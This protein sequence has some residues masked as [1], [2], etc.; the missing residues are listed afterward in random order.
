MSTEDNIEDI[1][2]LSPMQQGMLFHCL[3]S[4]DPG[5]YLSQVSCTLAP[6]FD[7]TAF[8]QAWQQVV[9]RHA[10]FRTSFVWEGL[11]DPVQV[12]WKRLKLSVER[13]DWRALS[14]SAQGQ[15]LEMHREEAGRRG[16]KL[17]AAPLLRLALIRLGE[18]EYQFNCMYH[19]LL[20]DGW[21]E[22]ILFAELSTAYAAL[23]GGTQA[24]LARP[25][26]FGDY[27]AWL[28][29]QDLAAA[30]TYWRRTLKG[31]T[32]PTPL[33]EARATLD[34]RSVEGLAEG[35]TDAR[36]AHLSPASLAALKSMAHQ[37]RLTLNTLTQGAWALLLGHLSGERDVVFGATVAGRPATLEGVE[38]IIGPFI[39][40]LPVRVRLPPEASLLPWLREL[41]EQQFEQRMFEHS[42]LVQIQEWSDAPRGLPLFESNLVFQNTPGDFSTGAQSGGGHRLKFKNMRLHEGRTNYALSLDI[43]PG[44]GLTINASYSLERFSAAAVAGI[45]ENLQTL[46]TSFI[47]RP[48]SN[49]SRLLE[50]LAEADR[51]RQ[52]EAEKEL[53][54]ASL[55][56]LKAV[57]RKALDIAPERSLPVE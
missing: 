22:A 50:T 15:R 40:T 11:D 55:Q 38:T 20:L 35:S 46:I 42:P 5:M 7:P 18:E 26:S 41:Q 49:L 33:H 17:S 2:P 28:Q 51:R 1:Y 44:A 37:H 23:A 24:N 16:L 31:F 32:S 29:R 4:P 3:Y 48:D 54:T 39:N 19:H 12:V 21:S 56:R 53:E 45:L 30:E 6:P 10:I 36:Q 43:E 57:R 52:S 8:E 13:H 27:I 34:A 14:P 9:D 25:G 47:T